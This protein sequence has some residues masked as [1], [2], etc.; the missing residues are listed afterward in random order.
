M[1]NCD[2]GWP[3]SSRERRMPCRCSGQHPGRGGPARA[4]ADPR[5]PAVRA[6][7]RRRPTR[8][9]SHA[10]S[11]RRRPAG[12]P[13]PTPGAFPRIFGRQ[14]AQ[15]V[16]PI[17][18]VRSNVHKQGA[19]SNGATTSTTT[20]GASSR[21]TPTTR[22]PAACTRSSA[23]PAGRRPAPALSTVRQPPPPRI[24][25]S[26]SPRTMISRHVLDQRPTV[27]IDEMHDVRSFALGRL[28]PERARATSPRSRR[29]DLPLPG[30]PPLQADAPA[31]ERR[32]RPRDRLAWAATS[33]RSRPRSTPASTSTRSTPASTEALDLMGD[34]VLAP[35][36]RGAG[37]RD[38]RGVIL[39]EIG[40]ANDNPDDLV[41]EILRAEP[42]GSAIPSARRSSEP[43]ETVRSIARGDLYAY[44]RARYGSG[45]LDR[46]RRRS[47]A[48]GRG[49]SR[50]SRRPSAR[51][52][53][54]G[55][56]RRPGTPRSRPRAKSHAVLRRRPASS[57]P[58]L[59]G[60]AR[61]R[62]SPS[63]AALRGEP[64][65]RRPRRRHVL[66]TLPG[67]AREARARVL[68]RLLAPRVSPGRLRGGLGGVRDEEP[69]ARPGGDAVGAPHS[70]AA[71]CAP[72]ELRWAKENLKGGLLLAL[73]STGRPDVR[74][75]APG[76][77]LLGRPHAA[78]AL[79][80][81]A[82]RPVIGGRGRCRGAAAAERA[83]P[84]VAVVGNVGELPVTAAD[85]R[86][87]RRCDRTTAGFVADP[88]P[89]RTWP[90]SW[91]ASGQ[92]AGSLIHESARP[93]RCVS[94]SDRASYRSRRRP[95]VRITC[96]TSY[97]FELVPHRTSDV[98]AIRYFALEI[99][100]APIR[101]RV[102]VFARLLRRRAISRLRALTR[103]LV[104]A[105]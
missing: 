34:V 61:R 21:A 5:T 38:E 74:G 8:G 48:R 14:Q 11:G 3:S 94:T 6:T 82:W 29:R 49:A 78:G 86:A 45:Q 27:L 72:S 73:E 50:G 93:T 68:D 81:E 17:V 46:R 30:A 65:R 33:T 54:S 32:D 99:R 58:R 39:E 53:A 47:C 84:R 19:S 79:D 7:S 62:P 2:D 1:C 92:R 60:S 56:R 64:P 25:R 88:A 9:R 100:R 44:H 70:N 15:V 105:M 91:A 36:F 77:L 22:W 67:G 103:F 96:A 71:A 31:L 13:T 35:A 4:Q 10:P 18:G 42:S 43:R 55:P 12:G 59:P 76:V 57:R 80:R 63:R 66:P 20:S 40:E 23:E 26:A 75:C 52:A 51:A 98:A 97:R 89:G 85:L 87:W 28:R 95:R 90:P 41:H 104:R 24:P 69:A 101:S 37:H 16:G 83:G 102:G